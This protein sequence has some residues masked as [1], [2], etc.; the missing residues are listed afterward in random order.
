MTRCFAQ[1]AAPRGDDLLAYGPLDIS[2]GLERDA[3]FMMGSM[4]RQKM[5]SPVNPDREPFHSVGCHVDLTTVRA[6]GCTTRRLHVWP[7]DV[8]GR[9][10]APN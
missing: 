5:P 3:V 1:G 2:K 6:I 7:E 10:I 9:P 8:I 4:R